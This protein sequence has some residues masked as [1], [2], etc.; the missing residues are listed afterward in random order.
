[1]RMK[2][3]TFGLAIVLTLSACGPENKSITEPLSMEERE[4]LTGRGDGYSITFTALERTRTLTASEK[5]TMEGLTYKRLN[6]FLNEGIQELGKK[7][8]T[9]GD[10]WEKMYGSY[11]A[12]VDSIDRHWTQ[13]MEG[14]QTTNYLKIELEDIVDKTDV[15]LGYVK[16]RLRLTPLKGRVDKVS[17]TFGL[18][19][20]DDQYG[21]IMSRNR[22][23]VDQP[24]SSSVTT[25]A[26]MTFNSAFDISARKVDDLPVS[27]LL[28]EY[29]FRTNII[30]LEVE[31][32]TVS[33]FDGYNQVPDCVCTLWKKRA[34]TDNGHVSDRWYANVYKELIDPSMPDKDDYIGERIR[35]DAYKDDELAATFYYEIL[36]K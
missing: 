16:V 21:S 8:A 32:R 10:E 25:D 33:Y 14:Y 1:M 15:F 29:D 34:D 18:L 20:K 5:K 24:F 26:S 36:G 23:E 3:L 9:Y 17:A 27:E 12:K 22:L 6:D 31:G 4:E 7:G 19:L 28:N 2:K 13:F 30:Q 35:E 11:R